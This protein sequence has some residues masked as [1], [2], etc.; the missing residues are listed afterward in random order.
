VVVEEV[1]VV[2]VVEEEEEEEKMVVVE[3]IDF[4][5]LL[6]AMQHV[7]RSGVEGS[8]GQVPLSTASHP[9]TQ[10]SW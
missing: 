5:L 7:S 3:P 9:S 8:G 1:V 10:T 6:V 2:V 4:G